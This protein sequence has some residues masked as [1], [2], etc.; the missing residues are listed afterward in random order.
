MEPSLTEEDQHQL[1]LYECTAIKEFLMFYNMDTE[2]S[3][4]DVGY[5]WPFEVVQEMIKKKGS[6]DLN[7]FI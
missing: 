2:L 4:S 5:I 7:E 1:Y 3:Y 6:L